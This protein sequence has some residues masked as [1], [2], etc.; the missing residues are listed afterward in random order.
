MKMRNYFQGLFLG[1]YNRKAMDGSDS[2][3]HARGAHVRRSVAQGATAGGPSGDA[4]SQLQ[5][6]DGTSYLLLSDGTS[7][8]EL[9]TA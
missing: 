7:Y 1:T 2:A 3:S 8:L 4:V 5:L 6:S 9:G